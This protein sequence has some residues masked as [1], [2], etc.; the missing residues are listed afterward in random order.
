MQTLW[1]VYA[2]AVSGEPFEQEYIRQLYGSDKD[3]LA[4]KVEYPFNF[5]YGTPIG[6]YEAITSAGYTKGAIALL[7][8]LALT[9]IISW[10]ASRE[11]A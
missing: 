9:G 2:T 3:W 7:V 4:V 8:F 1:L 5:V 6:D 11:E 10:R